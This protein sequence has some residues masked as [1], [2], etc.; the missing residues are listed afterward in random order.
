MNLTNVSIPIEPRTVGGCLDLA[1]QFQR[2]HFRQVMSLTAMIGVPA[3]VLTY[4]LAVL[5]S[6]GLLWGLLIHFFA[7]PVAG[8]LLV[9]GV[10]QRVFG[11]P[12]TVRRSLD[13]FWP[14]AFRLLFLP[15]G[16]G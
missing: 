2:V 16:P 6:D 12:L 7:A 11:E 10:G 14:H 13:A 1:V 8:A 9:A 4:V 5:Y 15:C 3:C